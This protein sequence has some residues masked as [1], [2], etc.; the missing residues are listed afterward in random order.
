MV[1]GLLDVLDELDRRGVAMALVP[2]DGPGPLLRTD[3]PIDAID[4]DLATAIG[5]HRDMIVAVLLGRLTGHAP[6]PCTFCGEVSMVNTSTSAG[7][8]RTSWP[9]CRMTPSCTGSLLNEPGRHIPRPVDIARTISRA[10]PT[11]AQPPPAPDRQRLYGP[12]PTWPSGGG[13]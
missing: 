5:S 10:A 11:Q 12:W 3:A 9:T 6:A 8:P 13:T 1:T 2:G 7:K 4:D